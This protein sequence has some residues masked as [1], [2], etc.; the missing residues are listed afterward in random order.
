MKTRYK[1]PVA[2]TSVLRERAR[3]AAELVRKKPSEDFRFASAVAEFALLHKDSK[4]KGEASYANLIE[5]ALNA[6]GVDRE[7]LR[8]EFIRLAEAA[9][10][11]A[12]PDRTPSRK[13]KAA[14]PDITVDVDI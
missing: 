13:E 14:S 12:K 11:M 5:R 9:E 10:L 8:A 7:G 3:T 2:E 4:F 6:K 1:L